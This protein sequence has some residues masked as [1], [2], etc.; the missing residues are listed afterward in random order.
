MQAT[1]I[2]YRKSI[3]M[4]GSD[5]MDRPL[6]GKIEVNWKVIRW[7]QSAILFGSCAYGVVIQ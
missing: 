3:Y 6:V 4:I 5:R 2:P 7:A 1:D